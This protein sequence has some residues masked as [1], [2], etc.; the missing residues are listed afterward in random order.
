MKEQIN[1]TKHAEELFAAAGF[2]K[3]K[4]SWV[5]IRMSRANNNNCIVSEK[6]CEWCGETF[7]F[8]GMRSQYLFKH[9]YREGTVYFCCE[10]CMR[11]YEEARKELMNNKRKNRYA[12]KK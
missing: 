5:G 4:I 2:S 8:T 11:K 6:T 7:S 12:I 10:S 1:R 3:Q 9:A